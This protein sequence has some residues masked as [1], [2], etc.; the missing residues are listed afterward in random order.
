MN[1]KTWFPVLAPATLLASLSFF[2]LRGLPYWS[3]MECLEEAIERGSQTARELLNYS[4]V[5]GI[6]RLTSKSMEKRRP[7]NSSGSNSESPP[8][9][10]EMSNWTNNLKAL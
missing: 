3:K 9:C 4:F 2:F 8:G 6:L 10:K 1:Q 5:C 7:H